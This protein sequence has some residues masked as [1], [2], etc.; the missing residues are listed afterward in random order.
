MG[1]TEGMTGLKATDYKA[2]DLA[3]AAVFEEERE[4]ESPEHFSRPEGH[5]GT[6]EWYVHIQHEC[7]HDVVKAYC[8]KFKGVL[9]LPETLAICGGC[10]VEL[11]ARK[12]VLNATKIGS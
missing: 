7:G 1:W 3:L 6:A 5:T 11:P 10:G 9:F 12:V 8:G 4:C 2:L